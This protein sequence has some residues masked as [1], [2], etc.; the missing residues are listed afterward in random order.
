[1]IRCEIQLSTTVEFLKNHIKKDI[2]DIQSTLNMNP[3]DVLI[4]CHHM[5]NSVVTSCKNGK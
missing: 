2:D 5:L 3:D 1:M 4:F